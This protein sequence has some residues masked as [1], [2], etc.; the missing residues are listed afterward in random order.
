MTIFKK[1]LLF[2]FLLLP[3][4]L[5]CQEHY[6]LLYLKY[7]END[8]IIYDGKC[9]EMLVIYDDVIEKRMIEKNHTLQMIIEG[10]KNDSGYTMLRHLTDPPTN[11]LF[12]VNSVSEVFGEK[13][14]VS[15]DNEN[16]YIIE[17]KYYNPNDTNTTYIL[18]FANKKDIIPKNKR[19]IENMNLSVSEYI[20]IDSLGNEFSEKEF[21]DKGIIGHYSSL[22]IKCDNDNAVFTFKLK[23]QSKNKSLLTQEEVYN[24]KIAENFME[25]GFEYWILERKDG[26]RLIFRKNKSGDIF[27]LTIPLDKTA[28]TLGVYM[29]TKQ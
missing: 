25:D 7:N 8:S 21:A 14:M 20:Y 1:I 16:T 5:I 18:Y 13:D 17:F 26:A 11:W 12:R 29:F 15:K 2:I 19:K 9:N 23:K 27:S 22:S 6:E 3:I 10:E 24:Y 28:E 4:S